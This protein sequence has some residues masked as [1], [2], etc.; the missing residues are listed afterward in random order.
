MTHN[1]GKINKKKNG[2]HNHT[3][4]KNFFKKNSFKKKSF[5]STL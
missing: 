5:V 1:K 2:T 3:R 4:Q